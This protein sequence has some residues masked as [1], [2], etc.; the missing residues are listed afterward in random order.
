MHY[1]VERRDKVA[2]CNHR[3]PGDQPDFCSHRWN[4]FGQHSDQHDRENWN[5]IHAIHLLWYPKMLDVLANSKG[6]WLDRNDDPAENFSA[7]C[8]TCSSLSR[9]LANQVLIQAQTKQRRNRSAQ[10]CAGL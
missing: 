8:T 5:E 10:S 1:F 3:E 2:N 9:V 6:H 7:G 4:A